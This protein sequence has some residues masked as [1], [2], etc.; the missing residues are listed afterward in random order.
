MWKNMFE[1]CL[2]V[3]SIICYVSHHF[4]ELVWCLFKLRL[5]NLCVSIGFLKVLQGSICFSS[6]SFPIWTLC[7][8]HTATIFLLFF[9]LLFQPIFMFF[10][11]GGISLTPLPSTKCERKTAVTQHF[12]LFA[13][14][15]FVL[16]WNN[17]RNVSKSLDLGIVPTSFSLV[18]Q[19]KKQR[20]FVFD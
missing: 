8:C 20:N 6:S 18:K 17:T 3:W 2:D 19:N 15:A 12:R 10:L 7:F 11:F 9:F 13:L 4:F 1:V 14:C 5:T 16:E